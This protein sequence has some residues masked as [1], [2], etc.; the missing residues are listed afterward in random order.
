MVAQ[1]R[2]EKQVPVPLAQKPREL[3]SGRGGMHFKKYYLQLKTAASLYCLLI[4]KNKLPS[5]LL[6]P[7]SISLSGVWVVNKIN[8][9]K[10]PARTGS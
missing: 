3:H 1:N 2:L 8:K 10:T 7:F 9:R 5:F 6:V 4:M